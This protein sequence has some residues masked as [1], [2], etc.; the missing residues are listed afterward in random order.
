METIKQA[1]SN[2]RLWFWFAISLAA[3]TAFLLVVN[4]SDEKITYMKWGSTELSVTLHQQ[5]SKK[6]KKQKPV[7]VLQAHSDVRIAK[8]VPNSTKPASKDPTGQNFSNTRY[9]YLLGQLRTSLSRHLSYPALA[10]K[11][12]W[13]GIV[14]VGL[15]IEAD[16]LL[17]RIRIRQSSG[18]NVLD[19]SAINS[20]RKIKKLRTEERHFDRPHRLTLRVVYQLTD[21]GYGTSAF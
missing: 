19:D 13:Q 20:L 9:N 18:Y 16:G 7:K 21:N 5:S 14:T 10:R 2:K 6:H 15:R 1:V 11:Q 3:H 8:V 12:G 4:M 17:K